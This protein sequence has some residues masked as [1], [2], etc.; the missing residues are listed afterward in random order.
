MAN[1]LVG[2]CQLRVSTLAPASFKEIALKSVRPPYVGHGTADRARI[3]RSRLAVSW[4][5][6]GLCP[7]CPMLS[8]IAHVGS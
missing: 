6:L 4:V 7:L 3:L 2:I 5:K 1:L 8:V